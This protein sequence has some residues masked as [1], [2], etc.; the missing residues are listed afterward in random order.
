M[1]DYPLPIPGD[2]EYQVLGVPPDS[3]SG[4]I[5]DARGEL[6]S[7]FQREKDALDAEIKSVQ[8]SVPGLTQAYAK[9]ASIESGS[10]PDAGSPR[11]AEAKAESL[12]KARTE[13]ARLEQKT[14]LAD[15]RRRSDNLQSRMDAINALGLERPQARSAY[16]RMHPPLEL[17]QIQACASEAFSGN[18]FPLALLRE[19][20][21]RFLAEQGEEVSH[22]SDLTRADFSADFTYNAL[23]DDNPPH[24]G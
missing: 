2:T 11:A 24:G 3:T 17:L 22:P 4:E 21:S 13:I 6:V 1:F 19:E 15:I 5:A 8:E 12:N 10:Q 20:L 18:R 16:N 7:G 9:L 23:L 14:D